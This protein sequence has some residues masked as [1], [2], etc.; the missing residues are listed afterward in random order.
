MSQRIVFASKLGVE[1]AKLPYGQ[2]KKSKEQQTYHSA[3]PDQQRRPG[4]SSS[5]H[6]LLQME[7]PTQL[8][9]I[10]QESLQ[11]V[12]PQTVDLLDIGPLLLAESH[13]LSGLEVAV[14]EQ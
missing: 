6:L 7:P 9:R 13:N 4:S 10:A 11:D 5:L 14:I 1:V 2:S 3:D 8:V 12:A